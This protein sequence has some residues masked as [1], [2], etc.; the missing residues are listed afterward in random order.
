MS[1]PVRIVEAISGIGLCREVL[2][3]PP[4]PDE[5]RRLVHATI[6]EE[7][8][9]QDKAAQW[10]D[11]ARANPLLGFLHLSTAEREAFRRQQGDARVDE[12]A[13]R[14][15]DSGASD[16]ID[17]ASWLWPGLQELV[18]CELENG[19]SMELTI[20]EALD[21]WAS[22]AVL[23]GQKLWLVGPTRVGKTYAAAL[24]LGR[25]AN[26]GKA[27]RPAY[28]KSIDL[29]EAVRYNAR[30]QLDVY[31]GADLVLLDDLF[32]EAQCGD[33]E[34]GQRWQSRWYGV[35]DAWTV[36]RTPLIVTTNAWSKTNMI[37]RYGEHTA[38]RMMEGSTRLV[39]PKRES[40][41]WG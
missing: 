11:E 31:K 36:N 2:G 20:A 28:V 10:D 29:G 22:Q 15:I 16:L 23:D 27:R 8:A 34:P 18:Q 21:W 3:L 4:L 14:R 19:N 25:M 6:G 17:R 35:V 9:R 7:S 5:K 38:Q 33:D 30:E 12:L 40:F 41:G 13:Q 24:L 32:R 39:W 26:E 37:R 1:R